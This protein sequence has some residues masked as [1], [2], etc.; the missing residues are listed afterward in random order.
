MD[1]ILDNLSNT[2]VLIGL[3]V[4]AGGLLGIYFFV[5]KKKD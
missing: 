1:A 4:D 5:L 2:Y 3:V